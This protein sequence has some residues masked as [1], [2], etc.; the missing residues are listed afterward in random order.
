[1]KLT[2]YNNYSQQPKNKYFKT[3]KEPFRKTNCCV[4]ELKIV[5]QVVS[6]EMA[7]NS[8]HSKVMETPFLQSDVSL[9]QNEVLNFEI[10]KN[11]LSETFL[12]CDDT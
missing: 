10:K 5:F 6:H 4:I 7:K 9:D 1:M 3:K 11:C 2:F 8:T 12:S